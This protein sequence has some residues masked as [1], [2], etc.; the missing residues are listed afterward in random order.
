MFF[1]I[2]EIRKFSAS[3]EMITLDN[4]QRTKTRQ[5]KRLA[6]FDCVRKPSEYPNCWLPRRQL[7]MNENQ[8]SIILLPLQFWDSFFSF[9]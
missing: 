8:N 5:D 1:K 3:P 2:F 7:V 4:K 6:I 9:E